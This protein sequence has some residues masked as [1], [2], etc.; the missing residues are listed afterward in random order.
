[1]NALEW[2]KEELATEVE[3]LR[4]IAEAEAEAAERRKARR[5]FRWGSL[6]TAIV[7]VA[8]LLLFVPGSPARVFSAGVAEVAVTVEAT[9]PFEDKCGFQPQAPGVIMAMCL[10]SVETLTDDTLRFNVHWTPSI[11]S[12]DINA[13]AREPGIGDQ[14]PYLEGPDGAKYELIEAGGSAALPLFVRHGEISEPGTLLFPPL[15][16]NV[17]VVSFVD[18][19]GEE[20]GRISDIVIE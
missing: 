20:Q 18:P 17:L 6:V 19:A 15:P 11:T 16:D 13:V 4:E 3:E 2:I 8:D 1:M 12:A 5:R 10:D 7:T 9:I 14:A